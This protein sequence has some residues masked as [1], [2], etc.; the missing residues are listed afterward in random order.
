M[1]SRIPH[2]A[3]G[4]TVAELVIVMAVLSILVALAYPSFRA[5]WL[6][7]RRTDA[8]NALM[9][10][11]QAQERWRADHRG[12]A[13]AAELAAPGTSA[14]GHYRLSVHAASTTGYELRAEALGAQQSDAGCRI[15]GLRQSEGALQWLAGHDLASLAPAPTARRCWPT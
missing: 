1:L 12:Y 6:K 4:F 3:R 15:I 8:H 14:N 13:S 10:L 2:P 5:Q 9:Q 11:Q 7:G